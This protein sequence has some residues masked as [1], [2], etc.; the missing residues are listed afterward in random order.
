MSSFRVSIFRSSAP[1]LAVFL[2]ALFCGCDPMQSTVVETGFQPRPEA[3]AGASRLKADRPVWKIGYQWQYA[4]K[5]AS[6][7][8]TIT[9]EIIREEVFGGF[10]AFVLRRADSEDFYAKD[11]LG[12]LGTRIGD[13]VTTRRN[14]PYQTLLWPLEV[15]KD[16]NNSYV[17]ERLEQKSSESLDNRIVVTKLETVDVPAGSF[18]AFK[19]EVYSN[20]AGNLLAEY[21][22][23]PKVKWFAKTR[24]Y[25]RDGVR[26]EEL[27]SFKVD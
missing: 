14:A 5:E 7:S 11:V 22:Y 18:E 13:R 12:L 26:E 27:Q 24:G 15:G 4:W 8:G 20:R 6:S 25:G 9:K 19:I 21:W 1:A 16:W 17:I 10:P 23:A 3:K 2:A